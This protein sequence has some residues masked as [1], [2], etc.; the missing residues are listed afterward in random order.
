ME[1]RVVSQIS[2]CPFQ[3]SESHKNHPE[4]ES[5]KKSQTPERFH[6]SGKGKLPHVQK[7]AE[8]EK[9]G[10]GKE[11]GKKGGEK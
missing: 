11:K 1:K 9:K 7:A 4:Q 3:K 8:E 2:D 10:G 6:D 5:N